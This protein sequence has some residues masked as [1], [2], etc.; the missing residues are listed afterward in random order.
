V[1]LLVSMKKGWLSTRVRIGRSGSSG[2][3][4]DGSGA[5][6]SMACLAAGLGVMGGRLRGL[7]SKRAVRRPDEEWS[8]RQLG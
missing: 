7:K 6:L 1:A 3:S 2:R 8:L 4:V 5:H